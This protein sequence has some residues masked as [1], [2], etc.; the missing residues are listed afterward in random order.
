L[1]AFERAL[2]TLDGAPGEAN[3]R[4]HWQTWLAWRDA[5]PVGRAHRYTEAQIR[6]HY[7]REPGFGGPAAP[8]PTDPARG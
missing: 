8:N 1:P 4:A 7:L 6:Y 5:C 2:T 3:L